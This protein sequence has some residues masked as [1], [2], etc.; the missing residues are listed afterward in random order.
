MSVKFDLNSWDSY[1]IS[2]QGTEAA[3]KNCLRISSSCSS[4]THFTK[5]TR[6]SRQKQSGSFGRCSQ[7]EDALV[8]VGMVCDGYTPKNNHNLPAARRLLKLYGE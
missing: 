1:E 8:H 4:C 3:R 5:L 2:Q 7:N 6:G